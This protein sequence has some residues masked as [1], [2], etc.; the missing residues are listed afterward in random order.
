MDSYIRQLKAYLSANPPGEDGPA[1][2]DLME[3]LYH[4]HAESNAGNSPETDRCFAEVDLHTRQLPYRDR[5]AICCAMTS[6]CIEQDRSA[7]MEGLQTGVG[8]LLELLDL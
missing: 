1:V 8:L 3:A 4:F 2:P 6:L 7:F 5:D